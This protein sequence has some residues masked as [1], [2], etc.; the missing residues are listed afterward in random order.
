MHAWDRIRLWNV[1]LLPLTLR[2]LP[3]YTIGICY[4]GITTFGDLSKHDDDDDDDPEDEDHDPQNFFAGGD[5]SYV[6]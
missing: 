4:R 6:N 5:R 3:F 2:K 1:P